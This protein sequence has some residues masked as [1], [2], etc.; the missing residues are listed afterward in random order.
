M[1]QDIY[2]L[3]HTTHQLEIQIRCI[4]QKRQ[5]KFTWNQTKR[6]IKSAFL[7][8]FSLLVYIYDLQLHVLRSLIKAI[9]VV[10]IVIKIWWA[11]CTGLIAQAMPSNPVVPK[12]RQ[13]V[14]STQS[15]WW[16]IW[17]CNKLLIWKSCHNKASSAIQN[18][19]LHH[20]LLLGTCSSGWKCG[21]MVQAHPHQI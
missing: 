20:I 10:G 6:G 9:R 17:W 11:M 1:K 15:G 7:S 21:A 2:I 16:I 18:N 14:V 12:S 19:N 8:F 4:L 5:W 3:W 13:T